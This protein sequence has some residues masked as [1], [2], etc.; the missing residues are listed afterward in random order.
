MIIL[1]SF[2]FNHDEDFPHRVELKKEDTEYIIVKLGG[3][4]SANHSVSLF[5]KLEQAKQLAETILNTIEEDRTTFC[6]SC[7][8]MLTDENK[9]AFGS[10]CRYCD[11]QVHEQKESE[12]V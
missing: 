10:H 7:G 6:Q 12:A 3:M 5:L 8:D 4:A 11:E 1:T 9:G 2:H